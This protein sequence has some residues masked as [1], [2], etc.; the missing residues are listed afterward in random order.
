MQYFDYK[1]N[2]FL[3]EKLSTFLRILLA[4][5]KNKN[6]YCNDKNKLILYII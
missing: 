1:N 5:Q 4:K 6:Q 3:F 2:S